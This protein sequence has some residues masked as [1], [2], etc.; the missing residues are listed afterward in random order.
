MLNGPKADEF[1]QWAILEL[2][3]HQRIA[4]IKSEQTIGGTAFIRVDVPA[5][6]GEAAFTKLFGSSAIY[7]VMF[8]SEEVAMAA[9]KSCR[10]RP[11]TPYELPLALR[12]KR[13]LSCRTDEDRAPF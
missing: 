5:H 3:G 6:D 2:M 4:G 9:L 1:H 7:S 13:E 12:S 11:V 10:A 8:V